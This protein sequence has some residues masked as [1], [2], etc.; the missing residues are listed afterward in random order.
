MY[1]KNLFQLGK[2]NILL[3]FIVFYFILFYFILFYFFSQFFRCVLEKS[4][5]FDYGL[6]SVLE[7]HVI[8]S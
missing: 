2:V 4:L 5:I 3:Y 6:F 7:N 1:D 8:S